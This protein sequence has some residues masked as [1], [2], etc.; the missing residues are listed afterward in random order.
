MGDGPGVVAAR[1]E[2]GRGKVTQ[3]RWQEVKAIL[4]GALE[5]TPE[6]RRVYLDE[7]CTEPALRR[8]VESLILAHE[9]EETTFL[10]QPVA[11]PRDLAIGS[12]LGPY[13]ILAR[14]GAGGMGVVYR[15]RDTRLKRTVAIKI[16][17]PEF[18]VDPRR[19]ERLAAEARTI[20]SLTHPNICV[21]YDIGQ[22]DG[23]DYLVMEYLEGET[24]ADRIS[25]GPLSTAELLAVAAE[26]AD[27][28]AKAHGQGILHRDLKPSNVM[29]TKAGA[30]LLDFGLAI[31]EAN[32]PTRS[33]A[34]ADTISALDLT[35]PQES[36]TA[37]GTL[38]GTTYYMSPEVLEGNKADPRSDIF[39]FGA[40]L[41][42][43][44]TG[45]R[46]F[47]GKT[48]ATVIAAILERDPPA[49]T[50]VRPES[51]AALDQMIRSCLAKDPQQRWQSMHD[52]RIELGWVADRFKQP[53][54][55]SHSTSKA[56]IREKLAWGAALALFAI[57]LLLGIAHFRNRVMSPLLVRSSILPPPGW[58]FLPFDFA[59]APDGTR[60]AFVAL[61]KDGR[62]E[63]GCGPSPRPARRKL[64]E[65]RGRSIRSGLPIANESDF[66]RMRS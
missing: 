26:V 27:A 41:Y 24:L 7:A 55:A 36:L 21:L 34:S 54:A 63:R 57:A 9:Q 10:A 42:E 60:L 65:R 3:E 43:M 11:P 46:A 45:K 17:Q 25:R 1:N 29:L 30:K 6:E 64:T 23:T 66:S 14:I 52:L 16:L 18:F 61:N 13:E 39:A 2:E 38:L 59:V 35:V 44:A 53:T 56:S 12:R 28:L 22:Q 20:S 32:T 31:A 15:A 49:V 51:P 37:A 62:T 48:P 50:T 40:V 47:D 19:R 8:E 33:A 4:A 5:R 58:S